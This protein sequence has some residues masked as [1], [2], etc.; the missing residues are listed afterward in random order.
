MVGS[1]LVAA[2]LIVTIAAA[3]CGKDNSASSGTQSAGPTAG[4][5]TTAAAPSTAAVPSTTASPAPGSATTAPN[6]NTQLAQQALLTAG[7]LPPGW[8]AHPRPASDAGSSKFDAPECAGLKAVDDDPGMKDNAAVSL[9]APDGFSQVSEEVTV[10]DAA[11]IKKAF[12]LFAADST[13]AC[14]QAVLTKEFQQAGRLPQGAQF[15]GIQ[16]QRQPVAGGEEAIGFGGQMSLTAPGTTIT[17]PLRV[18]AIRSGRALALLTTASQPG[19]Q[20][21]DPNTMTTAAAQR[22]T[23]V[24]AA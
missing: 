1:G 12:D 7:D 24:P 15:A 14:L 5:A 18:D 2:A 23:V 19:A 13:P 10:S 3:G 4:A 9:L 6:A 21:I 17:I 16:L 22:L 11:T 20:P 8:N